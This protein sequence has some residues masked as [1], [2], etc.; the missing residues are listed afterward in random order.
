MQDISSNSASAFLAVLDLC[1]LTTRHA[2][3]VGPSGGGG[4]VST[5][6]D[7]LAFS[8][9][10]LNKGQCGRERILS[11]APHGVDDLRSPHP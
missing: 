10:M 7:Y 9:M 6:D 5:I 1:A 8:R 2:L 3:A 11:R 4:L